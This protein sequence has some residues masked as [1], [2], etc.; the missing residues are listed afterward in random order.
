MLLNALLARAQQRCVPELSL[1]FD[2]AGAEVRVV[3]ALIDEWRA[4]AEVDP[5]AY[6][7]QA[8]VPPSE[9]HTGLDSAPLKIDVRCYAYRGEVLLF[10]ARLYRGWGE[11]FGMI[12]KRRMPD[13]SAGSTASAAWQGR[14]MLGAGWAV[15]GGHSG[16]NRPHR[17]PALQLC[18]GQGAPVR[19]S[20]DQ[21]S[22]EAPGI[23]IGADVRHQLHAGPVWL[24]YLDH[25]SA[26]GRRLNGDGT[27]RIRPLEN[28]LCDQLMALW[29]AAAS[30]ENG[31][32]ACVDLLVG[33]ECPEPPAQG[34]LARVRALIEKLPDLPPAEWRIELM[35]AQVHLS[36]SRFTH[37]FREVAGMAV[38]PYVRWLRLAKALQEARHRRSL[39]DAA[40]AAGFAD[41]AHLTRTMQRHFGIAPRAVTQV[42]RSDIV[43][44][45]GRR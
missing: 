14:A 43:P 7:A 2:G 35:A 9:R 11:P 29:R 19:V 27:L 15:F 36:P 5:Q 6:V 31:V 32:R 1:G 21:G 33:A 23:L 12:E 42:L 3:A 18:I 25:Q 45:G 13:T 40:H 24:L 44:S 34:S 4:Q 28:A 41:A 10:A 37:A 39:T 8:L 16:D 20:H 17:H 26:L 38:R 22:Q 30:P